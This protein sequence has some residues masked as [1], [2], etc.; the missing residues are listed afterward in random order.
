MIDYGASPA[1]A[2]AYA[3]LVEA[4][5]DWQ[6]AGLRLAGRREARA[7]WAASAGTDRLA[8]AELR[9]A[10]ALTSIAQLGT[11]D[12]TPAK[13]E[14]YARAV[15]LHAAAAEL[16][17]VPWWSLPVPGAR[18]QVACTVVTPAGAGPFPIVL[19]W[20]G[21]SG[22]GLVY[23]R[24]ADALTGAGVAAALVELPGQGT[25]RLEHGAV[26]SPRFVGTVAAIGHAVDAHPR[27]D[28]GR[29]GLLGN[30]VGGLLAALAAAELHRVRALCVNG[31]LRYPHHIPER[32]PRQLGQWGVMVG[33]TEPDRVR[34]AWSALAFAPDRHRWACPT[35]VLHG[36]RD[37]LVTL[38][39][40]QAFA[41]GTTDPDAEL[42]RFAEG[43]HCLYS[44]ADERDALLADWFARR[45]AAG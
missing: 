38:A 1:E 29:I 31:G 36:D 6:S 42:I 26:M 5:W 8:S 24:I 45:L 30:S 3:S 13:R 33:E 19:I 40:A 41:E 18:D 23:H 20:G 4:G 7:R 25:P 34:A 17:P 11:Y 28:G 14:T 39:D 15:G 16:A 35:L 32:F 10:A 9:T 37:R 21:S 44:A 22:W 2:E 43:E 27:L 12:D